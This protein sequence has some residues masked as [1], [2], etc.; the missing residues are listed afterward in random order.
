MKNLSILSIILMLFTLTGCDLAGDIF[1]AG[2]YTGLFI[3]FLVIA[4]IV[5]IIFKIKRK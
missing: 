5:F 4:I 3:V 2:F 1:S